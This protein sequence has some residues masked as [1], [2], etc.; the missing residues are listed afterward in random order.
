MSLRSPRATA[1][2]A[3]AFICAASAAALA[4]KAGPPKLDV[5]YV[6]TPQEVVDRM[7]EVAEVKSNDYV[8]D[9]GSGDGRIPITAAKKYGAKA[10]GVDIDPQR[11]A[12][13]EKNAKDA[14]VEDK[15]TFRQQNLFDTKIGD[16]TVLTMYLLQRVNLQLRPRILDEL[17]P[18]TRV[19]SHAFDMEEWKPDRHETVDGRHVY[20]WIVPAKV[21]G[22]WKVQ[23]G[24]RSFT[25]ELEQQFQN[26][27]GTAL[28]NGEK[29][30]L[31]NVTL[32]GAEISF[33]LTNKGQQPRLFRGRVAGDR[34]E[35]APGAG[36]NSTGWR[37]TRA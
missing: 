21:A 18:G 30:P 33:E 15:V 17:K 4:Q 16:A 8:I 24:E 26:V 10:F 28:I 11:I 22:R 1:I 27:K 25:I 23:D 14:K 29:V 12:E 13:A 9:L 34:I 20:L 32:R 35:P 5:P 2:L 7:L 36:G 31:Q 37:A 3:A 6:P 19:V